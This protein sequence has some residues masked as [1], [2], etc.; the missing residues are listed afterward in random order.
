MEQ[1]MKQT[2]PFFWAQ[3]ANSDLTPPIPSNTDC[4]Q[5]LFNRYAA[6]FFHYGAKKE[7]L[8]G[9]SKRE[10]KPTKGTVMRI[11]K[12]KKSSIISKRLTNSSV[13]PT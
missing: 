4:W 3:V 13:M 2:L 10:A 5:K 6:H 11:G 7:N 12:P 8:E 9:I 1:G